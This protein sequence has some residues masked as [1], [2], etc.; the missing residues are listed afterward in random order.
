[1]TTG[2]DL[3]AAKYDELWT[4]TDIG[5]LQ[6]EAVWRRVDPLFQRGTTILDLGCGTG[7]DAVHFQQAGVQVRAIDA[8]A[9]MVRIASSRGVDANQLPIEKVGQAFSLPGFCF[10]GAISNFGALNCLQ[11]LQSL[12]DPLQRLLKPGARL[13]ICT[14]GRTCL[15]ES[16]W[17]LLHGQLRKATR[18]WRGASESSSLGVRVHYHTLPEIRRALDPAFE[19]ESWQGIGLLV[20]PSYISGISRPLLEFFAGLDR[21]VARWPVA[22]A[23]A[24]HRLAIFRRK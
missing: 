14:I 10:D 15:W 9:E 16:A 7:E 8:S 12:R 3:I 24:D 17:Y 2:F 13:A 19:L 18:R 22:R 1:M 4:R 21:V 5:R 6:R 23:L 20:P 11:N